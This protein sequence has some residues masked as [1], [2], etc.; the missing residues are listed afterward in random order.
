M[1]ETRS[2]LLITGTEARSFLQGLVTNDV[3]KI[4]TGLVYAALLTP[5]G[6][7][8]ADFFLS[9]KD[10]GILLDVDADLADML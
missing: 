10:D 3:E 7:Y 2:L 9:A 4:D 5:H 8:M 6:K 1:G